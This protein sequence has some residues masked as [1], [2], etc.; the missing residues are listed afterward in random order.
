M[1][2]LVGFSLQLD[3]KR[4][5]FQNAARF[6]GNP[7]PIAEFAVRE[8]PDFINGAGNFR[9]VGRFADYWQKTIVFE[10]AEASQ[11]S[12]VAIHG[13]FRLAMAGI[14]AVVLTAVV[15]ALL[16]SAGLR[17]HP[18]QRWTP[19]VTATGLGAA[20][21]LSPLSAYP[22]IFIGATAMCFAVPWF[23][24]RDRDLETRRASWP[25]LGLVA[26]VG[27]LCAATYD[28]VYIAIPLAVAFFA[29]RCYV[30]GADW[31]TAR[32]FAA[33]HRLVALAGGF[34]AV[35]I[36]SRVAIEARCADGGCY[37]ASDISLS[38]DALRELPTRALSGFPLA[39][40]DEGG[41]ALALAPY[42]P[43]TM[44]ANVGLVA[45]LVVL[46]VVTAQ[47][48]V[49]SVGGDDLRPPLRLA[50][51]LAG[52]GGTAIVFG[53]TLASLSVEIQSG[54]FGVGAPWR[55]TLLVACGWTLVAMAA[56]VVALERAP[57]ARA[58]VFVG[59][60]VLVALALG[61]TLLT[62]ARL[63]HR[64]R[65]SEETRLLN[66]LSVLS[67]ENDRTP[68]GNERR[69]NAI[70]AFTDL[71]PSPNDFGGGPAIRGE[72]DALFE[73]RW[74]VPFCDEGA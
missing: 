36:P 14:L 19:L 11:V 50:V 64:D 55:E 20:S 66:H 26:L 44:L 45:V 57:D 12:P 48:V 21:F 28:L 52:V 31:A 73:G 58:A 65:L 41:E 67:I 23:V 56:L 10:T 37:V 61:A 59:A 43:R 15:A 9:P 24:V 5:L 7:I 69:C 8:V 33:V 70:D 18:L 35:F 29:A 42:G 6:D 38:V 40:W 39:A 49:R 71:R 4:T 25:E 51:A 17:D 68:D 72:L 63:S 22:F 34:V 27:T 2:P 1:S 53:A 16:R 74:G 46:A 32:G 13:L 47:V 30:A 60:G 3:E 54:A 62:N